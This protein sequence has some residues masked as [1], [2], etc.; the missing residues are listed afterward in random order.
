ML[1]FRISPFRPLTWLTPIFRNLWTWLRGETTGADKEDLWMGHPRDTTLCLSIMR[2][3]LLECAHTK[4]S[5]SGTP[6]C[7]ILCVG[8]LKKAPED[9]ISFSLFHSRLHTHLVSFVMAVR[10]L[11]FCVR[12]RKKLALQLKNWVRTVARL[13]FSIARS[14]GSG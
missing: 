2:T 7:R 10:L 6:S 14:L 9:K 1:L 11:R 4:L 5:R 13:L 3:V 8:G 12:S